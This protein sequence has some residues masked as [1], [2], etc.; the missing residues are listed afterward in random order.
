[1][2]PNAELSARTHALLV[3]L[4]QRDEPT[5]RHSIRTSLMCESLGKACGLSCQE[6][7]L[8]RIA[9][10]MHDIG[11]IG[12]PDNVL[13][14]STRYEAEDMRIMQTHPIIG[15]RILRSVRCDGAAEVAEAVRHH[16]EDF[17][18]SGYPDALSGEAIPVF[19]RI[20]ALADSYDALASTRPY[21]APRSHRQVIAT[22]HEENARRYDPK[23][24]SLFE[25]CMT[26]SIA[27]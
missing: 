13:K 21:H 12:I 9:G 27:A 11:K 19:S 16:H 25:Q 7:F 17:F 18:G 3:A 15:F 20:I 4:K 23:L 6:L 1:M 22:L 14:K 24:L 8:L 10:R 5:A 26:S 2:I